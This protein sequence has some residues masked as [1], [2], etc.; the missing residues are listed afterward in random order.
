MPE[1]V[2]LEDIWELMHRHIQEEERFRADMAKA[3][4]KNRHGD[5]DFDGHGDY[6]QR[7][8]DR[9]AKAEL[10]RDRMLEKVVGGSLWALVGFIGLAILAYLKDHI[11]K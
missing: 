9:A 11:F 7:L 3:F 6:H 1:H 2:T 10:A 5:I 8:I 4:P